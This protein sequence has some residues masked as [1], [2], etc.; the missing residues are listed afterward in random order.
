MFMRFAILFLFFI[1]FAHCGSAQSSK[2]DSLSRLLAH[3][4]A[5]SNRVTFLWRLA[6]QYQSINPDTSLQLSQQA[7]L[8][9]RRIKYTEGESRSLAIL[10]TSQYLLGNYPTALSNYMLKLKIE[11]KRNSPRNYV[12]ALSNIGLMYILLGEYRNAL[13]YLYRADAMVEATGGKT[14]DELKYNILVN[15]GE[16]YYRMKKPDSSGLYFRKALAI[17]RHTGDHFS[18]GTA[19]LGEANVLA[20]QDNNA[21]ALRYYYPAFNYLND[22]WNNET[23][24][25]VT[26]GMAKVYEKLNQV[27]S[28]YFFGN[29]SFALAEKGHFLLRQLDA[30]QFLSR[31]FKNLGE[32]DQA[33]TYMEQATSL[34]DAIKGQEKTREAM[35]ISNNE[36]MRQ[37][38]LAEQRLQEKEMRSQQLQLLVI[39]VCIPM[40]FLLTLFISRKKVHDMI[41]RYMGIISLLFLF[42][43][44]TLLLHPMVANFAHHIPLFELLIFVSIAA[45]IIPLHHRLEH[46]MIEKLTKRRNIFNA[47][48]SEPESE[49]A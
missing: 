12:S 40:L 2:I 19:M 35:M 37:A 34:N 44:I 39:A 22:G 21:A 6:E 20:L 27:D 7:L 28:A 23:L 13:S 4:K 29:K 31:H 30:A 45:G 26:L 16:T 11:E 5:D 42:E 14:R 32:Y 47:R 48:H 43:F 49:E 33:F 46:L 38:E 3:T 9:A 15:I 1:H 25:E 8:L 10:A 41:V 18:L 24:C 36:Q 17:A